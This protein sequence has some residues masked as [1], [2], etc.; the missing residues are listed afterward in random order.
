MSMETL[1]QIKHVHS[2]QD[3]MSKNLRRVALAVLAI[4]LLGGMA[5]MT[6]EP[7]YGLFAAALIL[8]WT[9]LVSL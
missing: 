9:Q 4:S 8:G 5:A 1:A 7:R 2:S 6:H 3:A